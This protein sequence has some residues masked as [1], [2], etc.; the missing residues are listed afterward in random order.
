MSW[1]MVLVDESHPLDAS[2]VPELAELEPDRQVDVRILEDAQ[3][4]AGGRKECGIEPVCLF[5]IPE[6]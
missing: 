5:G 4:D 1:Q 6:L 2:Y 3:R